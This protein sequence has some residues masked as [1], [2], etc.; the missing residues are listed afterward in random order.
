MTNARIAAALSEVATLVAGEESGAFRAAA[1]R[2]AARAIRAS[3]ASIADRYAEG[4][5]A[6]LDALPGVG[7]GIARTIAELLDTGHLTRLEAGRHPHCEA[8]FASVP[9]IGPILAHRIHDVLAV[10]TLEDLR[11]AANNGRLARVP[12]LAAR[13]VRGIRETLAG[14]LGP[15]PPARRSGRPMAPVAELLDVDRE[16]REKAARNLL[17]RI[18][19]HRFNPTHEAWLP[20]L[21]TTRDGRRYTALFSNTE[22]AHRLAKTTDW[23]VLYV[24]DGD[25]EREATIVTETRGPLADRRIVRGREAECAA[26]Y[27]IAEPVSD[28]AP[29]NA[30]PAPPSSPPASSAAG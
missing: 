8:A 27:G 11:A 16:Y 24:D 25:R 30:P 4:G 17:F 19:P 9:G 14:R 28:P 6:A 20:V 3:S 1:Y 18:A 22:T 10:H 15:K 12:G 7:P 29:S 5:V 23:V 13:R 26:Y 2:R 21:R